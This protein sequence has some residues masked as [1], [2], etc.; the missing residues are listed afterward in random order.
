MARENIQK[1]ENVY[2]NFAKNI[3]VNVR[4]KVQMLTFP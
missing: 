2:E 4:K 3:G 1:L